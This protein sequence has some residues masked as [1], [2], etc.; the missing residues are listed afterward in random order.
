M[1]SLTGLSIPDISRLTLS[2]YLIVVISLFIFF[3]G[4]N[5]E[6]QS[7]PFYTMVSVVLKFLM[8]LFLALIWFLIAK[9][10]TISFILLFFILYLAFTIFYIFVI[11]NTLKNKSL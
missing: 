8:E 11:L 3:T 6:L 1:Q 2:F 5:R 9:K 7:Q 4:Q 10:T